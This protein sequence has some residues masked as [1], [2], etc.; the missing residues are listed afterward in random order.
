MTYSALGDTVKER[1]TRTDEDGNSLPFK[2]LHSA[3][4]SAL[5]SETFSGTEKKLLA[6]E[7]QQVTRPVIAERTLED[8]GAS[9]ED[10]EPEQ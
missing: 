10:P 5:N 4:I 2:D 8:L 3:L 6:S 7:V 1:E 9:I